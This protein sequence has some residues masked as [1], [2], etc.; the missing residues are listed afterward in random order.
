MKFIGKVGKKIQ[1]RRAEAEGGLPP[2]GSSGSFSYSS[3]VPLWD[4][5][6]VSASACPAGTPAA[7]ASFVGPVNSMDAGDK[8]R[9]YGNLKALVVAGD[10]G[11]W[12]AFKK[13][14]LEK[15]SSTGRLLWHCTDFGLGISAL[16]AQGDQVWVGGVDGRIRAFSAANQRLLK[17]WKAHCFPVVSLAADG[18]LVY[19]L[20]AD[21]SI[22]GWPA[23]TATGI[24]AAAAEAWQAQ[25]A[26][27]LDEQKLKMLVG[28]WNVA[29]QKPDRSE[30]VLWVGDRARDAQLVVVGL[31]VRRRGGDMEK[32]EAG[33]QSIEHLLSIAVA[34][35]RCCLVPGPLQHY[36]A[37]C[38]V[39]PVDPRQAHTLAVSCFTPTQQTPLTPLCM[40]LPHLWLCPSQ[41]VGM[42]TSSVVQRG[43]VYLPPPACLTICRSSS[44]TGG[45][46]G[47]W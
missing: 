45:G 46:D 19:S 9:L 34:L 42:G 30:L 41:E 33:C 15:Y 31:Q 26:A 13:G 37:W 32:K 2:A 17:S 44:L 20:A 11:V 43:V 40:A 24:P 27:C 10:G 3:Q 4:G 16:V 39:L 1:E 29:E 7:G 18:A 23:A 21:G 25:Q 35:L 12:V 47:H 36:V 28:T 22:R 8:Q 38:S 5:P 6:P 14:L